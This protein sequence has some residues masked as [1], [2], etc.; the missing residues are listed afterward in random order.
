MNI[1]IRDASPE[2]ANFLA[3]AI[4]T[5]ARGCQ[6]Q[7]VWDLAFPGPE[8]ERLNLLAQLVLTEPE[9]AAHY[10]GFVIAELDDKPVAAAC[11]FIPE[12][13]TPEAFTEALLNVVERAGWNQK[14]QQDLLASFTVFS[15]CLPM[16]SDHI[17]VLEY[18]A[19]KPEARGTGI[20]Q[21][22]LLDLLDCGREAEA[23]NAQVAYFIGNEAAKKVY[24]SLGFN[25]TH[26]LLDKDFEN[27]FGTPGV[28]HMRLE[29]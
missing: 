15:R 10:S 23:A 12:E 26:E 7:C 28:M 21:E 13:K 27:D 20:T 6:T 24:R 2:D 17:W 19:T 18:I 8:D 4:L 14:Q 9:C 25:E 22:L 29:L 11:G 3:W 16:S 5:A 1:A